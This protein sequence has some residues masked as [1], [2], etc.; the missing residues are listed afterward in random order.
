MASSIVENGGGS[1]EG[2][3][4]ATFSDVLQ[5]TVKLDS[6]PIFHKETDLFG[7]DKPTREQWLTNVEMPRIYQQKPYWVYSEW[8]PCGASISRTW[9]TGCCLSLKE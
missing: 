1:L 4:G 6:K 5:G 7:K 3:I 8:V 2:D 9:L